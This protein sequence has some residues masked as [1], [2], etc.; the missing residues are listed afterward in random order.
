MGHVNSWKPILNP[1]AFSV[2]QTFPG[3]ASE[4]VPIRSNN[5]IHKES[6]DSALGSFINKN[7]YT[8]D[9]S[10]HATICKKFYR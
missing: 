9:V 3:L 2:Y 7:E 5:A 8:D 10:K 6:V 1:S 4:S